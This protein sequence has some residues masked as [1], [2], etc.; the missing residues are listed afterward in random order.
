MDDIS[1]KLNAIDTA[2]LALVKRLGKAG[3]LDVNDLAEELIQFGHA[4]RDIEG[5]YGEL[6][7]KIGHRVKE[8]AND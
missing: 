1:A 3:H 8:F 4:H 5:K 7:E 6:V 2:Y